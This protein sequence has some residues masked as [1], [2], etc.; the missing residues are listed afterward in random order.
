MMKTRILFIIL[1]AGALL[2]VSCKKCKTCKCWKSGV[3]FKET[4]CAYG[5]PPTT[6]SLDVW[7]EY[8]TEE[9]GYDSVRCV[10]E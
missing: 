9:S 2:F 7:E 8:L 4:N 5:F 6:S 3:E 1:L 10:L